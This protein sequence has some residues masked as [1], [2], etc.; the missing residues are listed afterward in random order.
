MIAPSRHQLMIDQ[1]PATDFEKLEDLGADAI[2]AARHAHARSAAHD[3]VM[4]LELRRQIADLRRIAED[5]SALTRA[6]RDSLHELVRLL[7][8]R[9]NADTAG[10][11]GPVL[12]ALLECL[13]ASERVA[14]LL[15]AE[16]HVGACRGIA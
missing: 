2:A 15:A 7:R 9:A 6:S 3:G 16:R 4:A 1:K 12:E 11:I 8:D 10:A 5:R 13:V 14:D